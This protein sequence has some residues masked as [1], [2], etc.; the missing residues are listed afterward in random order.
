M[1]IICFKCQ[2]K[3]KLPWKEAFKIAPCISLSSYAEGINNN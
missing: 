2:L 3:N 1:K